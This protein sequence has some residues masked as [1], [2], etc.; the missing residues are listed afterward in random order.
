MSATQTRP[1]RTL[2][3]RQLASGDVEDRP[4]NSWQ[5]DSRGLSSTMRPGAVVS[6][7]LSCA[8]KRSKNA[9]RTGNRVNGQLPSKV[10]DTLVAVDDDVGLTTLEHKLFISVAYEFQVT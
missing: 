6:G 7:N 9:A 10:L 5:R 8:R 4:S 3:L 1:I 2:E